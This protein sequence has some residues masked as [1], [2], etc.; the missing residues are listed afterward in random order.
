MANSIGAIRRLAEQKEI[1][2]VLFSSILN[3]SLSIPLRKHLAKHGVATAAIAYGLDATAP[4]WPYPNLVRKIF[5]TVDLIL[6]ISGA[7]GIECR[8]RGLPPEKCEVVTLGIKLDRFMPPSS[9]ADAKR[10]LAN[11]F[12][13]DTKAPP[14][15]ILSSVGR[16]IPRKGV[17]WFVN[18][19]MPTLPADVHFLIAGEGQ[20]RARIENA[21]ATHGLHDRVRLLGAVS[22]SDLS[23]LYQG[24][25]LF[26]MPNVPIAGDMEGFGLVMLEAGL[27]GAPVIASRLEGILDVI[28]EGENGHLVESGNAEKFRMAIMSYYENPDAL[29][30]ASEN[31]RAHTVSRFSWAGVT[32]KYVRLL[33]ALVDKRRKH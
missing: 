3:A 9:R 33:S 24:S 7:T 12:I 17:A 5:R 31:A 20:E 28:T 27:S 1:D 21:I 11:R 18:N 8:A 15:L 22:E 25:D 19:V 2:A 26:V 4:V 16:L 14:R 13:S 6:P 23:L 30:R 10:H 32:D 29:R